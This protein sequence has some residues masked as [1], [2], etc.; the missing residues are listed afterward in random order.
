[1][2]QKF[3][4]KVMIIGNCAGDPVLKVLPSKD[5][6]CYFTIATNRYWKVNGEEKEEVQF[7]RVVA[8]SKLAELC[9]KLITKGRK[10]YVE[11]RLSTRKFT[12][13]T[14]VEKEG[15]EIVL[16]DMILLDGRPKEAISETKDTPT[17]DKPF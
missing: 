15:T 9:G 1:M 14:G 16:E 3:L 10:V 2:S 4:N 8:W 6:L 17:G 11:G 5:S 7:H 12:D 13:K